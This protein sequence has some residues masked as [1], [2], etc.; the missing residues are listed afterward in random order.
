MTYYRRKYYW[1][2]QS[3]LAAYEKYGFMVDYMD[4]MSMAAILR[5]DVANTKSFA[6]WIAAED[7]S[8]IPDAEA[9]K[10]YHKI[11]LIVSLEHT[12]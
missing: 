7:A 12:T 3:I 5:T 8:T 4:P 1:Y 11:K 9:L 6:S 10:L 2:K